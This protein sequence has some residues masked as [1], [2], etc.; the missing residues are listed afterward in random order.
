MKRATVGRTCF[1]GGVNEPSL[2]ATVT[3]VVP[4]GARLLLSVR[5]LSRRPAL[6]ATGRV[7]QTGEVLRLLDLTHS[8]TLWLLSEATLLAEPVN[9]PANWRAWTGTALLIEE[10]PA[11]QGGDT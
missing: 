7:A 5:G 6:P 4:L 8:P 2:Q 1:H 10:G 11:Q 3:D 9:G